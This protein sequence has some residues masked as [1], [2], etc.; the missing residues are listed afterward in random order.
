MIVADY[1]MLVEAYLG[2]TTIDG[3]ARRMAIYYHSVGIPAY[4]AARQI[5]EAMLAEAEGRDA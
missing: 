2:M 1:L 4:T 3:Y 5:R